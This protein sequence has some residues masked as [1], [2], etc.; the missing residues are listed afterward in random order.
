MSQEVW[1]PRMDRSPWAAPDNFGLGVDDSRH[2]QAGIWTKDWQ[3][4]AGTS[5]LPSM[6]GSPSLLTMGRSSST[7]SAASSV[8]V[9]GGSNRSPTLR[10]M[11]RFTLV[12]S[13]STS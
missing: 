12:H 8:P 9:G 10:N 6:P 5:W 2:T 13:R 4:S 11:M 1:C 3:G 7:A